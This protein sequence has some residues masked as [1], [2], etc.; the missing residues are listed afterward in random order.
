VS[1]SQPN[2]GRN[3][4]LWEDLANKK[5]CALIHLPLNMRHVRHEGVIWLMQTGHMHKTN[6]SGTTGLLHL[7]VYWN[8]VLISLYLLGT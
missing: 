5:N 8:T 7:N 3:A 4:A 6:D 2:E 1:T